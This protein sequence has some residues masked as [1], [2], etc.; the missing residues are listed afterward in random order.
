M[1][2]APD[3]DDID[4]SKI[5]FSQIDVKSWNFTDKDT[6]EQRSGSQKFVIPFYGHAGTPFCYTLYDVYTYGGIMHKG[7]RKSAFIS[8]NLDKELSEKINEKVN[9][10]F[11]N[12]LFEYIKLLLPMAVKQGR[13]TE[14]SQMSVV[15]TGVIS[16][17]KPKENNPDECYSN[18]IVA[19][20]SMKKKNQQW[21]VDNEY[22]TIEDSDSTPYKWTSLGQTKLAEVVIQV[23]KLIIDEKKGI[24][25]P[26]QT[27][28][29]ITTKDK[30]MPKVVSKRK[31]EQQE[32]MHHNE[33]NEVKPVPNQSEQPIKLDKVNLNHE[34]KDDNTNKEETKQ[35]PLKVAKK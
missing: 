5:Q 27:V 1:E 23:E 31:L 15:F 24:I 7:N 3:V 10:G 4:Q 6:Q 13:I 34:K 25:Y 21:E 14:I 9:V 35:P 30:S 17:G 18:Q 12:R 16:Y 33:N 32:N 19:N 22:C 28:R 8:F 29:A 2:V 26:V 20:I 11:R